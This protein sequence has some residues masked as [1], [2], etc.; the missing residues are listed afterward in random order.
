MDLER[1]IIKAMV[2]PI[3]QNNEKKIGEWD[4]EG[5]HLMSPSR[6]E[7]H[8]RKLTLHVEQ[9]RQVIAHQTYF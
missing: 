9:D 3:S 2:T 4:N 6:A 7:K 5:I 1:T 8:D